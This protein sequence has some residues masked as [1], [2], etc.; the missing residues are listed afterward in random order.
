MI[1]SKKQLASARAEIERF[2]E[3]L[4]RLSKKRRPKRAREL[5]AVGIRRM[6][7]DLQEQIRLYEDALKGRVNRQLLERLLSLELQNGRPNFGAAISA[8]R[9]ARKMTQAHLAR[10]L[11]TKR[12]AIAR[13]E[14]DDY[15][16]YSYETLQRIFAALGYRI[17]IGVKAMAG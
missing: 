12:E 8:L 11:G 7:R 9:I 14:R 5:E 3:R 17:S 4:R 15:S 2:K 16:E 13:W 1:R 10:R 6:V